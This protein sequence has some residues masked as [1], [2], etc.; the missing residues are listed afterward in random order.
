MLGVLSSA[1][2]FAALSPAPVPRVPIG[3]YAYVV[4]EEVL[5]GLQQGYARND[6]CATLS[7]TDPDA[8]FKQLYFA[9]VN[10]AAVSGLALEVNWSTLNPNQPTAAISPPPLDCTHPRSTADPAY[11]WTSVDA[12]FCAVESWNQANPGLEP[13][14]VQLMITPGFGTPVWAFLQL[15]QSCDSLFASSP[16]SPGKAC[17]YATFYNDEGHLYQPKEWQPLPLPWDPTYQ[18]LYATFLQAVN[19]RYGSL[20]T[21]VS[22]AV[23]GP[24]G[25]TYE[26]ILPYDTPS[27]AMPSGATPMP[28]LDMWGQILYD[29]NS[30]LQTLYPKDTNSFVNSDEAVIKSWNAAI[31]TFNA[32]FS[33]ITLVLNYGGL[34]AF[35]SPTMTLNE[36]LMSDAICPVKPGFKPDTSCVT[37]ARIFDHFAQPCTGTGCNALASQ[38]SGVSADQPYAKFLN[39]DAVKSLST[40]SPNGGQIFGGGQFKVTFVDHDFSSDTQSFN[41]HF[42]SALVEGCDPGTFSAT[43]TACQANRQTDWSAPGCLGSCLPAHCLAPG[44]MLDAGYQTGPASDVPTTD[45]MYPEQGLYYALQNFFHGTLASP[46]YGDP[47]GVSVAPLNYLQIYY[48]DIL[49]ANDV[50]AMVPVTVAK[51]LAGGTQTILTNAQAILNNA[52]MQLLHQTSRVPDVPPPPQPIN[53]PPG[54]YCQH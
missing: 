14:S 37:N 25:T 54:D 39:L 47:V 28:Q 30:V 46:Y 27:S 13:E 26:M 23:D 10:N 8:C 11:D 15:P 29:Q 20:S 45:L 43:C 48:S 19:A 32:T 5:N 16:S 44:I 18:S 51:D 31:D 3:I 9:L 50:T 36:T 12:A 17:N 40:S 49:Y 7:T 4:V 1:R 52:S 53:C 42:P 35:T 33:N 22:I 38:F 41:Q 21:L 2:S 34:L 6:V 24:S